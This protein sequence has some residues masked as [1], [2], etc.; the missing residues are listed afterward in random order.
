MEDVH[1]T[2][3]TIISFSEKLEEASANF[4]EALA[5]RLAEHKDT[6]LTWAK[7]SRKNKL[8]VTRTYQ[9][10]ITDALEA[11][12]CFEGLNLRD[13]SFGVG[14]AP[15]TSPAEALKRALALEEKAQTFYLDVAERSQ[16]LLAT[17]PRAFRRVAETR[18]KRKAELQAMMG[19]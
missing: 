13:Y 11:C 10:T 7:E 9:E 4:Y 15:D 17:I 12:Y 19:K 18:D 16:A 1:V 2:T 5:E 8:L 6:F 14:L 3:A